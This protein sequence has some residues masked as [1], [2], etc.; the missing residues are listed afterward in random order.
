MARREVTHTRKDQDGDITALCN[1]GAYW[2]PR[3]KRDAISDIDYKFHQYFVRIRGHEVDINVINDPDGKYL[4]TD[5]DRT[6]TNNLD[7]LPDC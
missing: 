4:R 7:D 3:L 6:T 2:S 5:P 1:P